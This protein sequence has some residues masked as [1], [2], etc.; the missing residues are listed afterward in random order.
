M[1]LSF[2]AL[3]RGAPGGWQSLWAW[4]SHGQ[5]EG[6]TDR[7]LTVRASITSWK[8]L[9][10]TILFF[11]ARKASLGLGRGTEE[12]RAQEW[13]LLTSHGRA[14]APPEEVP[15][16]GNGSRL[17]SKASSVCSVSRV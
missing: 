12:G 10:P 9:F 2:P 4:A 6:R 13:N 8:F 11:T 16:Q 7:V 1:N 5:R 3:G 14:P 17:P 15:G